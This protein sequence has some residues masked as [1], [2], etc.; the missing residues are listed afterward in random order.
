MTALSTIDDFGREKGNI[1]RANVVMPNLS[2]FAVRSKYT[3]YDKKVFSGS[4]SAQVLK[5]EGAHQCQI[6]YE[7]VEDRGY[8]LSKEEE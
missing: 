1:G 2:P 3:L 8:E 5:I 7:I 6:G 4:E